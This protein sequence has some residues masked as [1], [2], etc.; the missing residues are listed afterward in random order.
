MNDLYISFKLLK[1][2]LGTNWRDKPADLKWFI[3]DMKRYLT[4][5]VMIPNEEGVKIDCY[6][7]SIKGNDTYVRGHIDSTKFHRIMGEGL[8]I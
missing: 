7:V 5:T 2:Q 4:G 8:K 6:T 1:A 3:K